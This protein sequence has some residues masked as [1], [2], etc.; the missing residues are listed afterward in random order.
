MIKREVGGEKLRK[1]D[2]GDAELQMSLI[3]LIASEQREVCSSG[4]L[5]VALIE[6]KT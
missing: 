5:Q 2:L 6:T 1:N 3:K 4:L